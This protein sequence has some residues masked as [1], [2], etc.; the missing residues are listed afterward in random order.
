MIAS[1]ELG[2]DLTKL[3]ADAKEI[4]ERDNKPGNNLLGDI[5]E[6][7]IPECDLEDED[8]DYDP[9]HKRGAN[10]FVGYGGVE[11]GQNDPENSHNMSAQFTEEWVQENFVTL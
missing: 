1:D 9:R 7:E 8:E 5:L 3:K 6:E 11:N 4:L 2:S 10:L